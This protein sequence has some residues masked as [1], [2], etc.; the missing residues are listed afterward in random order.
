MN[1]ISRSYFRLIISL[2]SKEIEAVEFGERKVSHKSVDLVA[3]E[4]N[5]VTT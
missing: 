3:N 4:T 1:I 5:M 2:I